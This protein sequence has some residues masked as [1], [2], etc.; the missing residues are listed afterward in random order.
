MC[1]VNDANNKLLNAAKI[2]GS[3]IQEDKVI[4][5]KIF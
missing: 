5:R 2:A 3:D 1:T 4:Y